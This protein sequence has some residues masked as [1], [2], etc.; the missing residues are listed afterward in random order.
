M[1]IPHPPRK[2]IVPPIYAELAAGTIIRRYHIALSDWFN[3]PEIHKIER[4]DGHIR[5]WAS[6]NVTADTALCLACFVGNSPQFWLGLQTQYDLD[7]S[8]DQLRK[9]LDR[10]VHP[11]GMLK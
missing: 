2:P 4:K 3:L 7:L 10:E 11:Y 1:I 9:R 8:E 5:V 6:D